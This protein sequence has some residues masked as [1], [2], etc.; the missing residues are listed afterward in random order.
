MT[1]T[2]FLNSFF[3]QE[4]IL[5]CFDHCICLKHCNLYEALVV[6]I[7]INI[8]KFLPECHFIYCLLVYGVAVAFQTLKQFDFKCTVEYLM[9]R[10]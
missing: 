7:P 6:H 3:P 1:I 9:W 4:I 2:F 10:Y 5:T 8:K